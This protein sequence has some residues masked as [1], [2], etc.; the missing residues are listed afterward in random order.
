MKYLCT[1]TNPKT[2]ERREAVVSLDDLDHD[3]RA[4]LDRN[5]IT[6]P[7]GA[8]APGGPIERMLA[9]ALA[10]KRVPAE[11]VYDIE[12]PDCCRRVN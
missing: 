11:F 4:F 9:Y 6:R 3:D 2:G 10:R 8:G 7:G 12:A 1:F 5:R